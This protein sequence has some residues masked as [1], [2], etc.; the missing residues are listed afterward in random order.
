MAKGHFIVL[1]GLDGSGTTTQGHRL[2]AELSRR[3][4]RTIFTNEPSRGP[5]GAVLALFLS[6]RLSLSP[7]GPERVLGP[8][9]MALLFAAD[10]LDHLDHEVLPALEAGVHVV[11]DRYVASSFAY[12]M[13][14]GRD[15]LEWLREINRR[16]VRPDVTLFLRT[17]AE[18]CAAR[19][20]LSRTEES[21]FERIDE[22]RRIEANYD[23][24]F[25]RLATEGEPIVVLDGGRTLPEVEAEI[26]AH[27]DERFPDLAG[28]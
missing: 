20:G 15:N 8:D 9:L 22:Q 3:G 11:C 7:G 18:V 27:L 4:R 10:R 24:V 13:A 26:L 6:K 5:V 28:R 19:R 1:E 12:Q 25:D 14:G 17:P 21:L 16:A 2:A 23:L